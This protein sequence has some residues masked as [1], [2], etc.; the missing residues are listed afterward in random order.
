MSKKVI[1]DVFLE[2]ANA[3]ESGEF[4]KKV[5]IGVTTLGSE[6]GVENMVNGAQLAKSNLFD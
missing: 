4:G 3:I 6:H 5:K 1:A 2:V